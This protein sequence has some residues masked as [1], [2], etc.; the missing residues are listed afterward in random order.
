MKWHRVTAATLG[1]VSVLVLPGI[2]WADPQDRP[3]AGCPQGAS[4]SSPLG[5]PAVFTRPGPLRTLI[6]AAA[7]GT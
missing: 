1:C 4:V 7:K 6:T 3:V 5:R 2:G